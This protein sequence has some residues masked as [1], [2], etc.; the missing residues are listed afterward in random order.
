ML[1]ILFC[2]FCLRECIKC[3]VGSSSYPGS[4]L[5]EKSCVLF[6]ESGR[7]LQAWNF[8]LQASRVLQICVNWGQT[9]IEILK[10]QFF[11]QRIWIGLN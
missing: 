1:H 9:E 6:S 4:H 10:I 11:S 8:K 5:K 2:V 7:I 3:V